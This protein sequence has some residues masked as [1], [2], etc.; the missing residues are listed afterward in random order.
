MDRPATIKALQTGLM[1]AID[2][3]KYYAEVER[4]QTGQIDK[5]IQHRLEALERLLQYSSFVKDDD[6]DSHPLYDN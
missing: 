1:E 5:V 4:N 2:M 6:G 3:I